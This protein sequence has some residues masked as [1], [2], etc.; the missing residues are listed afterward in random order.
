M[1]TSS[2]SLTLRF[3]IGLAAFAIGVNFIHDNASFINSFLLALLLVMSVSPLLNWLQ[4]LRVPG[5]LAYLITLAVALIAFGLVGLVIPA[6][7]VGLQRSAIDMTID[8]AALQQEM[9][10]RLAAYGV[11]VAE[12]SPFASISS[13]EW[14]AFTVDFLGR[15]LTSKALSDALDSVSVVL[16]TALFTIFLMLEALNFTKKV[17]WQLAQGNPEFAHLY[18]FTKQIRIYVS[19]TA[20][21]GLIGGALT[22]VI[23]WLIGVEF[24]LLWGFAY[25]VLGFI[26][27]VGLW[28]ALIPPLLLAFF[29]LGPLAA[30]LVLIWYVV[31]SVVIGNVLKPLFMSGDLNLSPLWSIIAMVL[32]SAILGLPG[33]I[34]GV[35][36]TIAIRELLLERDESSR[37]LAQMMGSTIPELDSEADDLDAE[38]AA[39]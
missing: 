6:M 16:M 36:L 22:V 25:F 17:D 37:W 15:A 28:L 14:V 12:L 3:L 18:S 30:L 32:W 11:D 2:L 19:I 10:V 9:I 31:S 24:A 21:L 39:S 5:G 23:L 13:D 1:N 26:P 4:R 33:L 29:N 7:I 27:G 8:L 38:A 34:L 20:I 35:P